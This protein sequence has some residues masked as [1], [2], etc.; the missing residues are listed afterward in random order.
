MEQLKLGSSGANKKGMYK[1]VIRPILDRVGHSEELHNL[2][3]NGLGFLQED[4]LFLKI[5]ERTIFKGGTRF[6]SPVLANQFD[7]LKRENTLQLG[8]GWDKP[9]IAQRTAHILGFGSTVAGGV[10]PE[11]QKGNEQKPRQHVFKDEKSHY[12][13]I[14]SVG[15]K[16]EGA[17]LVNDNLKRY[18]GRDFPILANVSSNNETPLKNIPS[19][20]ARVIGELY[21]QIDGIQLLISC[22]NVGGIEKVRSLHEKEFLVDLVQASLGAMDQRGFRKPISIKVGGDVT[23]KE[24]C[25]VISICLDNK[26]GI[27]GIN[28]SG[29]ERFKSHFGMSGVKG[30]FSG[31]YLPYRQRALEVAAFVFN[32][33]KGKLTFTASGGIY[34]GEDVLERHLAGSSINEMMTG[35]RVNGLT[36]ADQANRYLDKKL[37]EMGIKNVEEVIGINAQKYSVLGYLNI[38]RS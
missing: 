25:E 37:K 19:D 3:R 8:A 16:S 20:F 1:E 10:T 17:W 6:I 13:Q 4:E 24:L 7:G 14:N 9:G 23:I 36:V 5:F 30:G 22:L 32:E 35:L 12:G 26:L 18:R 2:I 11:P 28:T 38:P 29:E 33:T 31:D 21:Y 34:S 15:L 27:V